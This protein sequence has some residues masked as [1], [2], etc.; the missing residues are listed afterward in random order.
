MLHSFSM[1]SADRSLAHSQYADGKPFCFYE[2]SLDAPESDWK[3][4]ECAIAECEV[5]CTRPGMET[6]DTWSLPQCE[7]Y[8]EPDPL[9]QMTVSVLSGGG[10]GVGDSLDNVDRDLVMTSCRADGKLLQLTKP[11]T[12][13]PLQLVRMGAYCEVGN[14]FI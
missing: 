13:T 4:E 5:N 9:L 3:W 14:S 2:G 12:V 6:P 1:F 8:I 10:V 11:L 7:E